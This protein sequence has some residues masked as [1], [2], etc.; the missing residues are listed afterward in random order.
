[1]QA[2]VGT[3][4]TRPLPGSSALVLRVT[5]GKSFNDFHERLGKDSGFV[6]H[7]ALQ[8]GHTV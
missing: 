8:K 3:L 1:V 7:C 4:S 5:L 6:P 2:A